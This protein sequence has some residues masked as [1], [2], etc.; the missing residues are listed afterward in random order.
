MKKWIALLLA[1]MLVLSLAACGKEAAKAEDKPAATQE[2]P[3]AVETEAADEK[4]A[5]DENA[6]AD[7]T[8]GFPMTID[9]YGSPIVLEKRPEAVVTAGPNCTEVFIE[10][11]LED[12]IIGKCCESHALAPLEEYQSI[13]E[14]IPVLTFDYPTIEAVVSSGADFV[15]GI[16][17]VSGGDFNAEALSE[18]DIGFYVN[19]ASSVDEVYGEIRDLGRIFGVE[20]AAED[21]IA[22]QQA[23]LDAV[24]EAIA[25]T[26]SVDVFCYDYDTGDRGIYTAG[27]TNIE[28]ELLRLAG[29]RNIFDD[30]DTAWLGVSVEEILKRDPD[31]IV[32]HDY[33]VPTAADKIAAIKSDPIL[34][35]LACVQNDRFVLLPLECAFPGSRTAVGVE[36]LAKGLHPECFE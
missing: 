26:K 15:Y 1:A 34:S 5:A 36:T 24:K 17:W 33:D 4:D 25:G 23:R 32:I 8:D 22:R 14:A 19:A 13:Y 3:A 20:D 6:A 29:A 28:C 16:D 18:Y 7:E 21:F 31:V 10:L 11:G 9:N 30:T 2:E 35:K 12:L 27:G